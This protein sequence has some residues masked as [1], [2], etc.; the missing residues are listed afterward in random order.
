MDIRLDNDL[1]TAFGNQ[2]LTWTNTSP[3]SLP[4][5]RFYMYL[6]AFKNTESTLLKGTGMNLFGQNLLDRDSSE[7]GYLEIIQIQE[8]QNKYPV[9]E[10]EYIQPNDGN[11]N[12]ETVLSVKLAKPIAP[13]DSIVLNMEFIAKMPR[14]LLRSGYSKNDYYLFV[15]WF[16]QIGVYE[17]NHEDVWNWNCH[18]FFRQTEF[19]ADFGNYDV[20]LEVPGH[21][22]IGATGCLINKAGN[23]EITS[24]HF[25]AYDVIDFAWAAY[26]DFEVVKD[27]WKNI[28]IELL[29]PPE[30]KM[31][32]ARLL[33]ALKQGLNYLDSHVGPYPYPKIT[34]IDPPIHALNSGFMEYPMLITGGS[35]YRA[36]KDIRTI[37]SLI[38]HE[39][40]H[41]YFMA[42]LA[43][44]EK[45]EAWLDEGLVT[46]YEDRILDHY[47][48]ENCS[49][50]DILG[51]Q[52]GNAENSRLEYTRLPNPDAGII[53]RPGW[54][55]KESYKGLV[56]SKTATCL[57]TLEGLIGTDIFDEAIRLY[58]DRWKFK[59]PRGRDFIAV[60]NDVT[61]KRKNDFSDTGMNWFFD[62]CIYDAV[63]CDFFVSSISNDRFYLNT[64]LYGDINHLEFKPTKLSDLW[65]STVVIEKE[66][67]MIIPVEVN[68]TFSNGTKTREFWN[69]MGQQK[70]FEFTQAYPIQSVY[71]DPKQKVYLDLDLNNNSKTLKP[72]RKPLFKYSA[73]A[74]H[75]IQSILQISSSFMVTR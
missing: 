10:W 31:L 36:P 43:S 14:L 35:F 9:I 45:E 46:Y 23:S 7:W 27:T 40:T 30:H 34:I 58:Y 42:T 56:Y 39:F 22:V 55:I 49:L 20:T 29:I 24:Y 6:N 26:P 8:K 17:K 16:P 69:G 28:D 67:D 70:I 11:E 25:Q 3:D 44:N 21:L 32:S 48:G 38:I 75:W 33:T 12:D 52:S 13:G 54:E 4:E 61:Q 41:Q 64:G 57:K 50:F 65:K 66:G 18:Q 59:H 53:A 47:Y 5:L 72:N 19:Y 1:K 71:I 51:Y 37:E 74:M 68:I 60:I 63:S 73:K 62:Q 15:H 2:I